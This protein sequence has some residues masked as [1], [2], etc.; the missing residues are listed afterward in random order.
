[1]NDEKSAPLSFAHRCRQCIRLGV[2]RRDCVE[3]ADRRASTTG[4]R[5]ATIGTVHPKTKRRMAQT[6]Y[7]QRTNRGGFGGLFP[8]GYLDVS[9]MIEQP[10]GGICQ[11]WGVSNRLQTKYKGKT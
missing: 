10:Q 4:Y 11:T 7:P 1:M 8:G 3:T 2:I 6:L 5:V 9:F